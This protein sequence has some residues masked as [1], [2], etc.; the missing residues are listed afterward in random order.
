MALPLF[1]LLGVVYARVVPP[2]E[3]PDE[4]AHLAYVDHIV[5]EGSLPPARPKRDLTG[6]ESYQ[7]PLDYLVS[8]A[9]LQVLHGGP[10]GYPFRAD[11]EFDFHTRGSRAFLARTGTE[12]QASAIRRLRAARLVWGVLTLW[13][14]VQVAYL[15]TGPGREGAVAAAAPFC[16]APQL[17]FDTATINNDTAVTALAS[18]T[19]YGLCRMVSQRE[20]A[21]LA[22]A[23]TGTAAGL[24]LWSKS[25]GLFLVLPL[26]YA[27]VVLWRRG[28]RRAV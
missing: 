2:G 26:L 24:A 10:V 17:I 21:A 23:L 22:G 9:L 8:A 12:S 16:L 6:Y 7:P 14:T 27:G 3:A 20:A 25:S 1:V 13:F 15:L 19:I 18:A 11:P 4:P 5:G 28:Q